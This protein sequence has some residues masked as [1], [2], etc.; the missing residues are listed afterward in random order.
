MT[1]NSDLQLIYKE[2][3]NSMTTAECQTVATLASVYV[4]F[5]LNFNKDN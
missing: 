2:S 4:M 3:G 5:D 1:P